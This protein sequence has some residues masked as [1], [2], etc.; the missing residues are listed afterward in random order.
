[1]LTNNKELRKILKKAEK[2]GWVFTESQG[3]HI[4][5]K[6]TTGKTTTISKSPSDFRVFMNIQKHLKT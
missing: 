2:R 5:G 3:S 6:H 1:M 4:K